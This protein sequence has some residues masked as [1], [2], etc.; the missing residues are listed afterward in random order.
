MTACGEAACGGT[1]V[2]GYCD[3]CGIAPADDAPDGLSISTAAMVAG[4]ATRQPS[5]NG[6]GP[7][8]MRGRLGA[9]VVSVPPV[10]RGDP[11]AAILDEPRVSEAHRYCGNAGCRQPVGRGRNG[12]PGC[13]TGFCSSC[14]TPFSFVPRLAPGDLL[15]GQYEVRGCIAHGGLGWIYLASD[16]N[17]HNRWVVLKGLVNSGDPDA[18]E[19]AAAEAR[20]LADVEHPNIVRIYNFVQH[21]DSAGMTTGYIVMEYV[22]GRSLKEIR[23]RYGS[24]LPAG[25]AVAYIVEIAPALGYLHGMGLAYCD[26]K[27]D[28][29][30]HS[31][32]QLK[33]IDLGATVPM[34]DDDRVIYGTRGFQ[35]PEISRTGP[36]VATD[37][38]TVGRAL[39]V[40]L[41]DVPQNNG[42][43]VDELPGPAEVPVLATHD[44]LYRAVLRATDRAPQ[45]RFA[46]MDELADQ[47]T[48][49]LHEIAA[50]ETGQPKPR[51]STYFSPQRGIFGPGVDAVG[52]ASVIAAIGV[53][54]V[55][56]NDSGAALL[57]TTSGT[58]PAQLE[59]ALALA[60][61][62][63][64]RL[65]KSSIEVPLRLVRAA[66][67]LG[68]VADARRRLAGMEPV[69]P[70]DW[71][72]TWYSGQCALLEGDFAAAHAD[73]D[74][75][76]SRLPGELDPKM[77]IAATAELL[78]AH[79]EALRAY[80]VVW[81]TNHGFYSAAFGS[82]RLRVR[83][84]DH[85]GAV[86]T[87][88][89]VPASSAHFTA[90]RVMALKIMLAGSSPVDEALLLDAAERSRTLALDSAARRA[91]VRLTILQTALHWLDAGNTPQEKTL[92]DSSFD[93]I[94]L[95]SAMERCYRTLARETD[96]IW[97]RIKL[98][99]KANRVRPRTRL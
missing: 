71:R 56:A 83:A 22:G 98:V 26:F 75:V 61:D 13:T 19:V 10:S 70:G 7:T 41:M 49:V 44:S 91:H 23:T 82:A 1:V 63:S 16:R 57:A 29:V 73:F 86:A 81:R 36:T 40:L 15:G 74:E 97:M 4:G 8:S 68:E 90:A 11:V 69:I 9:G 35:A 53:P 94:G 33:L 62:A 55:D 54:K 52:P 38:Y 3:V 84:G 27:P 45:R 34:D 96:D 50:V 93:E 67:E 47:L 79:Q 78:G 64:R 87:L 32:E 85:S 17:V 89:Q 28:N 43:F 25:H 31:D 99:E 5:R 18:M 66:L 76:Y 59:Q 46:S 92:L 58:P 77:A 60:F 42:C 6:A 30:M 20:A 24:P 72:L 95:R 80:D 2:D 37:V 39:A 21:V 88:D 12:K 65:T 51:V 48:G 14:G